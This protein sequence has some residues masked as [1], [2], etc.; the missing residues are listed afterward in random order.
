MQQTEK[1]KRTRKE[2][3]DVMAVLETKNAVMRFGGLTAVN[4][5]NLLVENK[6]IVAI[7]GPNGAGKTT[8]FNMITGVYRPTEGEIYFQDKCVSRLR[9]DQIARLGIAR[10]FQNIRLFKS[11]TVMENVLVAN[12]LHAKSNL[13]S[14]ALQF[15]SAR[16]E[17]KAMVERSLQL[18]EETGLI[19]YKDWLSTSLP[20]GL[21]RRLEIARAMTTNPKLLLLDEPAAGM[22]PKESAELAEFIHEIREKFDLT[23]LLIEHHMKLVMKISDL[24]YVLQYGKTIAQGT[25]KEIS[26]NPAVIKAYL[27][28]ED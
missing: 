8:A 4:N 11:M 2:R 21:Q 17:E 1:V 16:R 22:N 6:E 24:I 7:I 10:T 20:Y 5:L 25:P 19:D 13:F 23:I 26:E 9:P 28:E 15:P 18:L 3:G 12:H 14:S 27:G